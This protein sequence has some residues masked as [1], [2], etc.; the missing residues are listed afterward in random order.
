MFG[1]RDHLPLY[2]NLAQ[3]SFFWRSLS[4]QTVFGISVLSRAFVSLLNKTEVNGL[5]RFL[6]LLKSR[7]VPSQRTRGLLTVSNHL[8]VLDEPLIWGVLPLGFAALYGYQNHRW[9]LASHDLCYKSVLTSHFFTLGQCLPTHRMAHSESGGPY[10]ATMTE[11]VRLMSK[12]DERKMAICPAA[13]PIYHKN[14]QTPSWPR[15]C[16]D[17]FSDITPAPSYPSQQDD[18]RWYHAPSRYASNS[19]SWIHIFPEGKIH[20]SNNTTMRYFKW[21]VSRL[22]LEPEV[23][24]DVVPMWIE[25]FDK[26]MHESR[27]FPRFIPRAGKKL[28]VTF[29]EKLDTYSR[30]GDLRRKWADLRDRHAKAHGLD[31]WDPIL[32]GTVHDDLAES[33]EAVAL[34][35]ECTKRVRDA[36]LEVR[37]M[38]GL[39][40]EDPKHGLAET[41]A[42]EGGKREGRMDD[43]SW[44]KDT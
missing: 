18:G 7:S 33:E 12:I 31:G 19:Y 10:Q 28:S 22:I 9:T 21:G 41:W 4:H 43:G 14:Y 25:G 2:P 36:V 39:P 37:R 40:D 30:F 13:S 27:T 24:P 44:V 16:V 20:Q 34:R 11:A 29:G 8:S 15:D 42:L 26:V 3:P 6:E 38:R 23:C 17:P 1:R 32:L 35:I 5:P